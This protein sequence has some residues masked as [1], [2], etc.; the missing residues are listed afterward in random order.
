VKGGLEVNPGEMSAP[1]FLGRQNIGN[2][3]V[4]VE[5]PLSPEDVQDVEDGWAILWNLVRAWGLSCRVG[6]RGHGSRGGKGVLILP[7]LQGEQ[8]GET[9]AGL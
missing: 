9:E 3:V 4:P 1:V 8:Q 2:E 6:G 7:I 5:E